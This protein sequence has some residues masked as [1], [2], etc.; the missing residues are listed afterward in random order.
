M[1]TQFSAFLRRYLL[2]AAFWTCPP[3]GEFLR[4]FACLLLV[5]P[6]IDTAAAIWY[7]FSM[8]LYS[9]K[10]IEQLARAKSGNAYRSATESL[11]FKPTDGDRAAVRFRG[12]RNATIDGNGATLQLDGRGYYFVLEACERV[13]I[14]NFS[15]ETI[16]P[17]YLEFTV[18]NSGLTSAEV[19]IGGEYTPSLNGSA[20]SVF[21]GEHDLL[22]GQD[23]SSVFCRNL[24]DESIKRESSDPLSKLKGASKL[25]TVGNMH[26]V[27]LAFSGLSPLKKDCVYIRFAKGKD[28][29]GILLINCKDITL[30][31]IAIRYAHG[32][33]IKA[34]MC[35]NV[36]VQD[37]TLRAQTGRS[38][39]TLASA[40]EA[41]E[42]TGSLYISDCRLAATLSDTVSVKGAL[43]SIASASGDSVV[44]A[45]SS[46]TALSP[47]QKGDVAAFVD[48][49]MNR[50]AT[51]TVA[52]YD[53]TTRTVKFDSPVPEG[54]AT[55]KAEN[56]SLHTADVFFRRATLY[57]SP[58]S[59]LSF[60]TS[61]F[62][63]AEY[64]N[65][66]NID[67]K[68]IVCTTGKGDSAGLPT[69]VQA[70]S[71]GFV[72]CPDTS[73]EIA[74]SCGG[75][76]AIDDADIYGNKFEDCGRAAIVASR[77]RNLSIKKNVADT[78]K[79]QTKISQCGNVDSDGVGY[80]Y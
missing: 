56:T 67:G 59:G 24:S 53:K 79:Y 8:I 18:V 9:F 6:R 36:T 10:N 14:E 28:C 45:E 19:R 22:S 51:L 30:R 29:P 12:L 68:A 33:A 44:L 75:D 52:D 47:F 54:A 62:V 64:C 80:M 43:Y 4:P 13:L 15:L 35:E 38:V 72:Q 31:N 11:S 5:A 17:E 69:K 34:D 78:E 42:C 61:G 3:S 46:K 16:D 21:S 60:A 41:I 49:A 23:A 65:F 63:R 66:R 77:C 39:A 76:A 2:F 58:D 55:L 7:N 37:V 70:E 27:K 71:N 74:P 25:A 73:I 1:H 50:V 48:G 40:F 26:T 20:L 57:G 32:S